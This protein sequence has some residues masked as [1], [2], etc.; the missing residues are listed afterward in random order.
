ML[1]IVFGQRLAS[2]SESAC[3]RVEENYRIFS[4]VQFPGCLCVKRQGG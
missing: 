3:H 4:T 1:V 2:V